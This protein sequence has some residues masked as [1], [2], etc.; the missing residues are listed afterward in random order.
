LIKRL[1]L[2]ASIEYIYKIYKEKHL[3]KVGSNSVTC[4]ECGMQHTVLTF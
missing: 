3:Q 1:S 2:N 4:Q